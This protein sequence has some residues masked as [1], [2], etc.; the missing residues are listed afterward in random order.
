MGN[1]RTTYLM[2]AVV[3]GIWGL[4][5]W[6]IWKGLQ[7]KEDPIAVTDMSRPKKQSD[8]VSDQFTL[9]ANYRDPFLGKTF[10]DDDRPAVATP[11]PNTATV[12][13]T[14]PA[15][16]EVPWPELHYYGFVRQSSQ[17]AM[18]GFLS[19]SGSSHFVKAGQV[20]EGLT[21]SRVWLDSVEVV[22]GKEKRIVRK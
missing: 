22:R 18:T 4:I 20:I 21:I 9:I 5:G 16:T 17:E 15:V 12:Q 14:T 19:I 7:G 6:R 8:L 3:L 2:L 11:R 13:V 10:V 1:R